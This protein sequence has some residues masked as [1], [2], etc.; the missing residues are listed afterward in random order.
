VDRGPLFLWHGNAGGYIRSNSVFPTPEGA[1]SQSGLHH[2][3][4]RREVARFS[5]SPLAIVFIP[6]VDC[7]PQDA[8]T[9][10]EVIC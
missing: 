4:R 2:L 8:S 3:G 1:L 6:M 9:I 5:L 7:V 10:L